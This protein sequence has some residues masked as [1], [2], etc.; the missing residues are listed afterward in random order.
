MVTPD[1]GKLL[2]GLR[3]C[4]EDVATTITKNARVST[5]HTLEDLEEITS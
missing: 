1:M 4:L 5:N 3:L 2:K